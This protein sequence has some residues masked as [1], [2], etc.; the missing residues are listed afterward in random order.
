MS[1]YE[2]ISFALDTSIDVNHI[3]FEWQLFP[4]NFSF[5]TLIRRVNQRSDVGI[6]PINF[7]KVFSRTMS[8]NKKF[9]EQKS[10]S[11]NQYKNHESNKKIGKNNIK[12]MNEMNV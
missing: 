8:S 1:M 12:P 9:E 7:T 11:Q 5:S 4:L 6:A 3:P 10:K 2:L